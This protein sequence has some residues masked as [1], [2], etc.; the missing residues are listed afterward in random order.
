MDIGWNCPGWG[1]QYLSPTMIVPW[2]PVPRG[3]WGTVFPGVGHDKGGGFTMEP[4]GQLT[5]E[6]EQTLEP[7]VIWLSLGH[8]PLKKV[9]LQVWGLGENGSCQGS[10]QYDNALH[11]F[12][13]C[14]W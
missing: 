4:V 2:Q 1:M 12:P 13:S 14:T 10:A 5:H 7:G 6:Q 3:W 9:F 11:G 8:T